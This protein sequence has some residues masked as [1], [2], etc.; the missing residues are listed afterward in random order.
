MH[1]V[2]LKNIV[3]APNQ[4]VA[5]W[6]NIFFFHSSSSTPS[7]SDRLV[8]IHVTLSQWFLHKHQH[9]PLSSAPA[10]HFLTGLK[11][12]KVV[13]IIHWR[14]ITSHYILNVFIL[15]ITPLLA[16][17]LTSSWTLTSAWAFS[18]S[19]IT[20]KWPPILADISAVLPLHCMIETEPSKKEQSPLWFSVVLIDTQTTNNNNYHSHNGEMVTVWGQVAH[21]ESKKPM[22]LTMTFQ[23]WP[24]LCHSPSPQC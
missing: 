13:W 9:F 22:D 4:K 7:S 2:V 16:H 12:H 6:T 23:L 10:H 8:Q 14:T 19:L 11:S 24:V 3:K 18:S 20:S 1:L 5:R 21:K 17:A 15:V